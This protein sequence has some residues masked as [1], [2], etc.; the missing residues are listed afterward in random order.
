MDIHRLILPEKRRPRQ[1][2][3]EWLAGYITVATG[4]EL[5]PEAT[6]VMALQLSEASLC[7]LRFS[8]GS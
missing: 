2:C 1:S 6:T 4:T 8:G 7:G 3:A 5:L